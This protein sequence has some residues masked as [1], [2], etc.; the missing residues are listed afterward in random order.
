[1]I[2]NQ[3]PQQ[4]QQHQLTSTTTTI[5]DCIHINQG[6]AKTIIA[7]AHL[8]HLLSINRLE[9]DDLVEHVI[10]SINK[11]NN[12]YRQHIGSALAI[13]LNKYRLTS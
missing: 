10:A 4:K 12:N 9:S 3:K 5:I 7:D 13:A 8:S 6:R 1:M 11:T 2:N